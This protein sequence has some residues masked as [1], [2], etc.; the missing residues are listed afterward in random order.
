M[1]PKVLIDECFFSVFETVVVDVVVAT[2]RD[3]SQDR[4]V[5]KATKMTVSYWRI[6]LYRSMPIR[7]NTKELHQVKGN[8]NERT[9]Q[10]FVTLNDSNH[11]S[12]VHC[13]TKQR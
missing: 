9:M 3:R 7:A 1:A 13:V 6:R 2:R 5:V 10:R 4:N 8:R 11:G 12:V